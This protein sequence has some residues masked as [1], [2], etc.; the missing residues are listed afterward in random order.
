MALV[1]IFIAGIYYVITQQQDKADIDV[2]RS[3]PAGPLY[4][5]T[6]EC[7]KDAALYSAYLFGYQQGYHIVPDNSLD[8]VFYKIAYYYLKGDSLIPTNEFFEKEFSK[9][10]NDQILEKCTDFSTFEERGY[11]INFGSINTKT[12][13]LED[14][15]IIKVDYPIQIGISDTTTEISDFDYTIQVR[16]GHIL[17][18][19]RSIVDEIKKEPYAIDLTF[20]LNQDVDISIAN[21]D[22]CNQVYI[23]LDEESETREENEIYTYSFAVGFS[24][25][26]CFDKADIGNSNLN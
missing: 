1:L 5:Y 6:E 12:T 22:P 3:G 8:T 14:N 24:E 23:R 9:I 21:Y 11:D 16:L 10:M 20:L 19:S 13:I 7:I 18:I 25:E 2:Q 15:I 26:Y 4:I 17:D